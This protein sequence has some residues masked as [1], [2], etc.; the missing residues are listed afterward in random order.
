MTDFYGTYTIG[1][2]HFYTWGASNPN[3]GVI[4]YKEYSRHDCGGP[5][6]RMASFG[7]DPGAPLECD[8]KSAD[9]TISGL[10]RIVRQG[11]NRFEASP[12]APEEEP[13]LPWDPWEELDPFMEPVPV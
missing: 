2:R 7:G 6:Q 5:G 9:P 3:A 11:A 12:G 1:K 8:G 10:G 13:N 4:W